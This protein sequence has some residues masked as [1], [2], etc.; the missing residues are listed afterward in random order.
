MKNLLIRNFKLRK[1]TIILY[2]I[3]LIISPLQLVIDNNNTFT[4]TLYASVAMILLFVSLLDSGH[5]FRFYSKL[6]H[7]HT[8]DFF[9]SLP[10]SKKALLNAN[11]LTILIFTI[12]GASILSLYNMPNSDIAKNTINIS[13]TLPFSYITLNF[14]AVPIAFKRYTE[15]KSEYISFLTYLLVML[16]LIPFAIVLILIGI[17]ELYDY[18]FVNSNYFENSLNYG[19]LAVSIIFFVSNYFIQYNKLNKY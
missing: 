19:F 12:V 14:L 2:A 8:Y 3:L 7:K 17:S 9:G 6:G 10:V 15:Q 5:V 11:Y 16:I 1:W 4:Q 13:F 18:H